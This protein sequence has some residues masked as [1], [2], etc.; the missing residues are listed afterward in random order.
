MNVAAIGSAMSVAQW[1]TVIFSSG[2]WCI[3]ARSPEG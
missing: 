3:A 2:R 1:I